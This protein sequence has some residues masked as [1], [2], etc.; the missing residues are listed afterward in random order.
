MFIL[1]SEN[2][3]NYG[4]GQIFPFLLLIILVV[5]I[6]AMITVNLGQ[7]GIMKTDVSNAADAAALAGASILSA[8][9][10][11]FSMKGEMIIGKIVGEVATIVVMVLTLIEIPQAIAAAVGLALELLTNYI[12]TFEEGVMAWSSAKKTAL[13]YAFSNIGVD[14]PRPTFE[15]FMQKVYFMTPDDINNL[16]NSDYMRYYDI[17]NEGY[18]RSLF[19]GSE[20]FGFDDPDCEKLKDI[21]RYS[22]PGFAWFMEHTFSRKIGD[23]APGNYSPFDST[24]G[25]GWTVIKDENGRMIDVANTAEDSSSTYKN[26]TFDNWVEVNIVGSNLYNIQSYTPPTGIPDL[27]DEALQNI[28]D[29]QDFPWWVEDI[30]GGITDFVQYFFGGAMQVIMGLFIAWGFTFGTEAEEDVFVDN[31]PLFVTVKRYKRPKNLGIWN[32]AYGNN[33]IVSATAAA[34]AFGETDAQTIE[35]MSIGVPGYT[36]LAVLLDYFNDCI[37]KSMAG[38]ELPDIGDYF[39]NGDYHLYETE[40]IYA[41]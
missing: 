10:L 16:S 28:V 21:K 1:V 8:T 37:E 6:M 5:V 15:S 24:I 20:A 30:L 36:Q 3:A 27:I 25:Y 31:N 17:Y 18:D 11:N 32:F 22:Q 35:P 39:N 12:M 29:H 9:L 13:Q 23:I 19:C 7:I 34:R 2:K 40:L 26:G 4:K 14:E 38:E 41:Y 33:G